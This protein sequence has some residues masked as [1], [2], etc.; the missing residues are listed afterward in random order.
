MSQAIAIDAGHGYTKALSATAQTIFSSLICPA[1]AS[2]DL[3]DYA[4][5]QAIFVDGTAYLVGESAR[6]HATPLWSRDKATDPDTLRLILV[7]AA[8]LGANGPVALATGLPL[9]WY[10]SQRRAFRDALTGYGGTIQLSNQ[11][12]QRLWFESAII[13][14]QGLAAAGP[15]LIQAER[16]PGDYLVI[17]IGYRTTDYLIVSKSPN[18]RLDYAPDAAGSLPV[19]MSAVGKSVA[20]AINQQYQVEFS[21][22]EIESQTTV[23]IRGQ[24]IDLTQRRHEANQAVGKQLLQ[25]LALEL[26]SAMD[27]LIG[28]VAVGGGSDIITR[29]LPT[30]LVP[31]QPQWANVQGYWSLLQGPS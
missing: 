11:P 13:L 21:P 1:P 29:L 4:H 25:S 15:I 31:S 16:E 23:A 9:S 10:G 26:G 14:P 20:D 12:A 28:M 17:D 5:S 2:V 27:K 18:G 7:A 19:G 3:G 6:A 24:R 22:A 8:Q 30:A